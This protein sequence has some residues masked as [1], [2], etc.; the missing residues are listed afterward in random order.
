[1]V[2]PHYH[3]LCSLGKLHLRNFES[4]KYDYTISNESLSEIVVTF[5]V[6]IEFLASF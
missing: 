1:M 3:D 5:S 2:L 6:K 4:V